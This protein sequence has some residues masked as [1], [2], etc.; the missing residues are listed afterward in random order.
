MVNDPNFEAYRYAISK[1]E[2]SHNYGARNSRTGAIGR[3]QVMPA[4]VP[5]WTKTALGQSMTPEEFAKNS[6]AQDRT[7]DKIYGDDVDRYGPDGATNKWFTGSANPNP[8]SSDGNMTAGSYLDSFRRNVSEFT[9]QP[10]QVANSA[11]DQPSARTDTSGLM[12]ALMQAP[13]SDDD[14]PTRS[15]QPGT[16]QGPSEDQDSLIKKLLGTDTTQTAM[17][18]TAQLQPGFTHRAEGGPVQLAKAGS[19]FNPKQDDQKMSA[20]L[21]ALLGGS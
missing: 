6:N 15:D 2:S 11:P 12:Q 20:L 4:N 10:Y 19:K 5:E 17:L 1:Q 21:Q 8:K 18:P 13:S 7:F 9:G 3:Y 16:V 14:E